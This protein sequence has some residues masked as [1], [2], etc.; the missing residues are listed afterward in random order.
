MEAGIKGIFRHASFLATLEDQIDNPIGEAYFDLVS[1]TSTGGIIASRNL[2]WVFLLV[3]SCKCTADL[4]DAGLPRAMYT[5]SVFRHLIPAANTTPF[6]YKMLSRRCL[7]TTFLGDSSLRLVIPAFNCKNG[8]C[9]R[10]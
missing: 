6:P 3:T 9:P 1:G 7:K 5:K 2:G 10:L 4:G 8:H